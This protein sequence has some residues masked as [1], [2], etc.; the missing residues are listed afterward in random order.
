MR[1]VI[2]VQAR[3][4]S[5]R[6]PAKVLAAIDGRP[7]IWHVMQR[8]RAAYRADEVVLCT[9]MSNGNEELAMLARRHGWALYRG[10]E[11][12]LSLLAD[13]AMACRAELVVRVTADCPL[14]DP[15]VIDG[16]IASFPARRATAGLDLLYTTPGWPDGL[17][18]EV[19]DADAL[20]LAKGEARELGD[21]EHVTTWLRRYAVAVAFRGGSS[22][23]IP[24]PTRM[25]M[26]ASRF[27][28]SAGARYRRRDGC[29]TIVTLCGG[30]S[31]AEL[32]RASRRRPG[33]QRTA[34]GR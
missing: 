14:M 3:V 11:E 28:N 8:C 25:A 16:A 5:T 19:M 9:G 34:N 23:T 17:D 7:M 20:I 33:N 32:I 27:A 2:L 30:G 29:R 18:V 15:A 26:D 6:L 24:R 4:G 10:S 21:R 31:A 22:R 12:A 1:T 13:A